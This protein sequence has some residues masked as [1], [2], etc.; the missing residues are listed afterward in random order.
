MILAISVFRS[1]RMF[2][3]ACAT[4]ILAFLC[5]PLNGQTVHFSGGIKTL[6]SGFRGSLGVAVDRSGNVFVSDQADSAVKEIVAVGGY[7]TIY[8]LGSGISSS[9]GVAVDGNG[10]V[11]VADTNNNAVK[12]IIAAGGYTTVN[13]LGSGFNTPEGVAVDGNGNIF[14]AD[15]NNNAVKEIIAAGGCTTVNTL[16]SGLNYPYGVAVDSSGN[17]FVADNGNNAVKEILAAGGYTTVNTLGSGFWSPTGVAV[18]GSGNVFVADTNNNA[19]KEIVAAGGYTGVKTL[20]GGFN[21]PEGVAVD[22]SGNVFVLD[23]GSHAVKEIVAGGNF[24][25]V[26]VGA[27]SAAPLTLY[28]TFDSAGTLGST[29]VLTKGATGLD[30]TDAGWG[31]CTANTAY[32]TGDTCTINVTFSPKAPGA[33]YGAAEL[34][35]TTGNLVATG[36]VQG[37]GVG[38]LVNFLPGTLS[39]IDIGFTLPYGMAVDGNENI[40]VADEG[41]HLV[42]EVLA[43][44]GYSTVRTLGSGFNSPEG[45]AVDGAG[46]VFIADP[47]SDTVNEIVAAGGYTTINTLGSD[48]RFPVGVAVDGSGNLFVTDEGDNSVKEILAA[49]GYS[50]VKTLGSGFFRP[51]GVA[52]DGSGNVFFAD[53]GNN[54]VKEIVASG[55]YTTVNTLASGLNAPLEIAV[56]GS[57]NVF[58]A[59]SGNNNVTEIVAAGGYTT[60]KTL[61]NGLSSPTGVAVDGN[62]NVFV[63]DYGNSRLVKLDY[64]H[65]PSLGFISTQ[66]GSTSTD[67][68]QTVIV[69]NIGNAPL[70]ATAPGLTVP[71][72][73]AQVVGS[74]T[75]AECTA[76]FS[77]A[78][79][80]SC[81]LSIAF[82]PT[83]TGTLNESF[84]LTDNSLN[85]SLAAQQVQVSGTGTASQTTTSITAPTITYGN[86]ASVT[87]SVSSVQG[88]VTGSV[89]LTVDNGA[90]L[91][92]PLSSGSS[93]FSI[94]GLTAGSHNLSANYAAEG[95]FAASSGIGTLNVNKTTPTIS[96]NNI[97]T[98][99]VYGGSFTPTFAYTGDGATSVSSGTT[100]T[101]TVSGAVVNFVGA[102]MCTISAHATSGVNY[103]AATGSPQSFAISQLHPTIS[104]NN[105]PTGAQYGSSFTPFYVY[106]GDGTTSVT[107]G[108]TSICSVSGAV[109]NFVGV[110]ICTL[111]AHATATAN[112]AAATGGPQSFSVAKAVPTL[113][114]NNIPSSPVYGGSFAPTYTYTGNGKTSATSSTPATCTVSSKGVV[115]FASAG[116]CTLVAQATATTSN[117]AVTGSPQSLTIAKATTTISIKNIPTSAKHGG[118]FAPTY[119]YVGDGT[120]SASSSTPSV[121]SVS[122]SIVNFLTVGTCSLT[123][124]ATAGVDYAATTGIPQSFAIK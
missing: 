86:A 1:L 101:C 119:N 17:V 35:D 38:P 113:S 21:S 16:A 114:I 20:G 36:Y 118:S 23:S 9:V 77:L 70:T 80:E 8:T 44:G 99:A 31:T 97:P 84:V 60:V 41:L 7:T 65:A 27:S 26:N 53:N 108:T 29:A 67:S 43:A 51:L 90:P 83:T 47:G 54:A 121:C 89:S 100:A 85:V 107:S 52:V 88:T 42:K 2:V 34:L 111:T 82:V 92:Q 93:V 120:P 104:I 55:D 123:A 64:S 106:A 56:D 58:V 112:S 122:G 18:D 6:G 94:S 57:G 12:E 96:I 117:A 5:L 22:G 32:N 63:A 59:D 10:N 115:T 4:F 78:Q 24:G 39:P 91:S 14:V 105:I 3:I 109:V 81:N 98:G 48:F 71:A 95:S 103:A 62:G 72:D 28:F 13:T 37:T 49:D 15:T 69:A 66:V 110:G 30:F 76:S 73:F 46:N 61:G 11:F 50:T 79:G 74:G 102:G 68:P 33:R 19:V 45:V 124:K 75:S 116:T 87:V 25:L 40:F